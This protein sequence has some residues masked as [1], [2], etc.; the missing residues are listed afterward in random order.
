MMR[1]FFIQ[2]AER[3][4]LVFVVVAALGVLAAAIVAMTAPPPRGGILS[5]LLVLIVGEIYVTLMAGLMFVAFGIYRNG[6]ET[7]RLL[8]ERR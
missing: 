3:M 2:W 7:N 8:R 4:L 1:D 6:Q 5:G